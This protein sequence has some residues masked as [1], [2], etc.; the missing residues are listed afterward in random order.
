[1]IAADSILDEACLRN[2]PAELFFE[3]RNGTVTVARV[4][5]MEL[6]DSE[7]L[8]DSPMYVDSGERIP[9]GAPITVHLSVN[10][11]RYQFASAIID[12][13][14]IIQL[15]RHQRIPGI[16]M[17]LPDAVTES[18]RRSTLRISTVR[19]E[20]ISVSLATPC[21]TV[22]D[23][24]PIEGPVLQGWIVDLAIGGI[25][26]LADVGLA[27][28]VKSGDKFFTTF[29]LPGAERD[30]SMLVTVRH[31]REIE[32]SDSLRMGLAFIPWQVREYH[33]QQQ[34]LSRFVTTH[35]RLTL[36]RRK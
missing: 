7:L 26:I 14:K 34:M 10:G 5:L 9:C 12:K 28:G 18:Q 30:F 25:G 21:P 35:D 2:V 24:C 23:A 8:A 3:P 19:Y 16:A 22:P 6:T 15:N 27:K 11:N 17:K 32:R 31:T 33:V 1:M 36:Q 13:K 20:P 29:T 4:R